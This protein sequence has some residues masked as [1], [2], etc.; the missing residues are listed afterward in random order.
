MYALKLDELIKDPELERA[1]KELENALEIAEREWENIRQS[2]EYC[3]DTGDFSKDDFMVGIIRED[4]IVRNPL[5]SPTKSVSVFSP[6]YYP[7]YF[8][9]NL[10][11]MDDKLPEHGYRTIEALYC[12]IE[13]SNIA[14]RRLG[15]RGNLAMGF[16]AG[17]GNVR[18]GWIGEKGWGVERQKFHDL[19]FEGRKT[20]YEWEFF[21]DSVKKSFKRVFDK[22]SSWQSDH[23]LYKKETKPGVVIKP[24]IV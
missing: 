14:A 6:T 23:N 3:G 13:L 18:T 21:W 19:F 1:Q 20:D 24:N 10:I 8:V 11:I 2:L 7:M 22:F 17:Y 16:G 5:R 15:L 9:R 4:V 12:Y